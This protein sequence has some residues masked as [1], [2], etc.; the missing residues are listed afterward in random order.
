[1]RPLMPTIFHFDVPVDDIER[2]Q[3]FY[4]GLFNWTFEKYGGQ[5]QMDYFQIATR[6]AAVR[7][8][9]PEEWESGSSSSVD[10]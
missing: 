2:A 1:M 10:L 9:S 8:V 6:V 5:I 4:R 3:T 7:P